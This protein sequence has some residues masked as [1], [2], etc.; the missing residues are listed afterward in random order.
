MTNKARKAISAESYGT[1]N[2]KEDFVPRV[3]EKEE[4]QKERQIFI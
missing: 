2:K 1:W 4:E 3:I